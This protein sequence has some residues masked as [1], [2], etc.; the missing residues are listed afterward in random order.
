MAATKHE[1][2][3]IEN[4]S[5]DSGD[6]LVEDEPS[7]LYQVKWRTLGAIFALSLANVC[8][9]LSNTV[10]SLPLS[11][12]FKIQRKADLMLDEHYH[13]VPSTSSWKS[14]TGILDSKWQLSRHIGFRPSLRE[15]LFGPVN[16]S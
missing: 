15:S 7:T 5:R 1:V 11:S 4:P 16:S 8:A 9:A 12:M 2:A 3:Q 6:I 13:T 10:E 14:I